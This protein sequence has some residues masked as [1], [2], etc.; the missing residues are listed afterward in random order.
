MNCEDYLVV[1][2]YG[3]DPCE[4]F[5]SLNNQV[6]QKIQE[7]YKPLNGAAISTIKQSVSNNLV[8]YQTLIK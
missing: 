2:E 1:Y 5:R 7:G 4:L 3:T 6:R 8:A